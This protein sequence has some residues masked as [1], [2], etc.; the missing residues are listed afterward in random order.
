MGCDDDA[1][2][3]LAQCVRAR[4]LARSMA[5][6][7]V[8]SFARCLA[9]IAHALAHRYGS[10]LCDIL[11]PKMLLTIVFINARRARLISSGCRVCLLL[12]IGDDLLCGICCIDM[13]LIAHTRLVHRID[14]HKSASHIFL[15]PFHFIRFSSQCEFF[16]LPKSLRIPIRVLCCMD[17]ASAAAPGRNA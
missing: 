6:S 14:R 9:R 16:L 17:E 15:L 11:F 10:Y 5:C 4:S 3:A 7:L 13:A 12:R 8:C 1:L 2:V